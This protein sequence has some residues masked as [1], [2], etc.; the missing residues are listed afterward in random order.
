MVLIPMGFRVRVEVDFLG[1][2]EILNPSLHTQ[3]YI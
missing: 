1:K 2:E 3:K